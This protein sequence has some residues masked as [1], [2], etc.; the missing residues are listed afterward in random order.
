MIKKPIK[1]GLDTLHRLFVMGAIGFTI[2]CTSY[3]SYGFYCF[4]KKVSEYNKNIN[5]NNNDDDD[6]N[7]T[8]TN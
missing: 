5:N 2:L 7:Q 4:Y 3:Y 8:N 6:D 1:S